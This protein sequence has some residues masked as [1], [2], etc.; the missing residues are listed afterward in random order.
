MKRNDALFLLVLLGLATAAWPQTTIDLRTQTRD[1]DFSGAASTK[2]FKTGTSLPA[3]CTTGAAFLNL[4]A[5][6]GQNIY[7]CTATNTWTQVQNLNQSTSWTA[8]GDVSGTASGVTTL[9][10]ALTVTGLR[11][12]ALPALSTG[13]LRYTG[14]AWV[15]DSTVYL[16]SMWGSGSRPVAANALGTSGNCV[17]WG[18]VGLVDA[19]APC[20][21]GSG[22][23]SMFQQLGDFQLTYSGTGATVGALCSPSTP[24]LAAVGYNAYSFSAP[25]TITESGSGN[26]TLYV[27]VSGS[28]T[29]IV[30]YGGSTAPACGGCTV[31][32]GITSYPAGVAAIGRL[33]VSGGSFAAS[34]N[35]RA[36][37]TG[38]P[39]LAA[40]SNVTISTAGNVTTINSVI[41]GSIQF[42][43]TTA[44]QLAC[45]VAPYS[46]TIVSWTIL[47]NTSGA[48]QLDVWVAPFG[49]ALPTH[50][51]SIV[52]S[53][54]PTLSSAVA[55]TG[56][57]LTGWTAA[58]AKGNIV[59]VYVTSLSGL[60]SVTLSLGV[61]H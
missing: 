12:T 6:A 11:G 33:T 28:G 42:T 53:A 23:A 54:P 55:A 32:A 15:F 34:V 9:T 13:N 51:N 40:G 47:G 18:S 35:D 5:A 45:Q 29:L 49:A 48:A 31:A 19:G 59:C 24:C 20:G 27:Y 26:D 57:T 4:A 39:T 3:S 38:P 2:P 21:S 50:S 37:I 14:G 8:S 1:V 44:S 58:F 56:S 43:G 10:P 7:L 16:S 41:P 46:G 30:G 25:A 60:S 52:A 22:G 61:T 17:A 36:S